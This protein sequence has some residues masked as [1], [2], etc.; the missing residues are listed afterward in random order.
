MEIEDFSDIILETTIFN[1]LNTKQINKLFSYINYKLVL[2]DK[3]VVVHKRNEIC[4]NLIIILEGS[5]SL[6]QSNFN[7]KSFN[8]YT[9]KDKDIVGANSI[10]AKDNRYKV[11]IY[12]K[13]PCVLLYIPQNEILNLCQNDKIFLKSYLM[14]MSEKSQKLLHKI[15]VL[16]NKNIR[17]TIKHFLN[18]EYNKQKSLKI[19]LNITKKEL[20]QNLC[21][22]RTSLSRELKSMKIDGLIDYDKNSITILSLKDIF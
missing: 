2:F 11:D 12:T 21:I 16:S 3:D 20:A 7:N 1:H 13:T 15:K 17:S 5:L 10:F 22:E 19:K 18:E 4:E 8:I 14:H 9:F 6:N